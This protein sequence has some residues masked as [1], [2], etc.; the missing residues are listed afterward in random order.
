M[1][2]GIFIFFCWQIEE[3]ASGWTK[4]TF[5]IECAFKIQG[6][7][8]WQFQFE[9]TNSVFCGILSINSVQRVGKKKLFFSTFNTCFIFYTQKEHFQRF[10]TS[11]EDKGIKLSPCSKLF[12]VR[13][14]HP[15][16]F[17]A[18]TLTK[19][20]V[21][22]QTTLCSLL[23]RPCQSNPNKMV[24]SFQPKILHTTLYSF[25]HDCWWVFLQN[26]PQSNMFQSRLYSDWKYDWRWRWIPLA[27]NSFISQAK[28]I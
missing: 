5:P 3:L 1:T 20:M 8:Y 17:H 9:P 22:L 14:F 24:E 7:E 16:I 18:I 2:N 28:W 27:P 6:N 21:V 13:F 12:I 19:R 11:K 10:S 26:K 23:T 25:T 4:P 15:F